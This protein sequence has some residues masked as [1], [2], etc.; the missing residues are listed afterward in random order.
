[1]PSDLTSAAVPGRPSG[2]FTSS[3]RGE[4]EAY[5]SRHVAP[6]RMRLLQGNAVAADFYSIDLG[7]ATVV[8]ISY[9]ANVEL[10]VNDFEDRHIIIAT[11]RGGGTVDTRRDTFQMRPDTMLISLPGK[12]ATIRL[13]ESNRHLTVRMRQKAIE[14]YVAGILNA[15][16][17]TPLVFEPNV[18]GPDYFVSAWRDALFHV[19]HQYSSAPALFERGRLRRHYAAMMIDLL[20]THHQHNYSDALARCSNDISPWH[21][22]RAREIIEASFGETLLISELARSVGVSLRGLQTGFRHFLGVTPAEY[23]R[24]RRLERLRRALE[25]APQESTVAQLMAEHGIVNFGRFA[26]Y[27]RV[28]YGETPSQTLRRRRLT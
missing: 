21:V 3:D 11:L 20:L 6:H 12:K 5:L 7:V 22:R 19:M 26:Q 8:D 28:R 9:G 10:E 14:D 24:C 27:Y 15:S 2:K 18:S 25:S 16:I 13:G 17:R 4:V 1:M 23:I